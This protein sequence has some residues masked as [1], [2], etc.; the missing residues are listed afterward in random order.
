MFEL[1]V[2]CCCDQDLQSITG[3]QYNHIMGNYRVVELH[4]SDECL[5]RWFCLACQEEVE[6][7]GTMAPTCPAR[8][9]HESS[10]PH[11]AAVA[12]KAAR[13]QSRPQNLLQQRVDAGQAAAPD[14]AAQQRAAKRAKQMHEEALGQGP[15]VSSVAAPPLCAVADMLGAYMLAGQLNGDLSKQVQVAGEELSRVACVPHSGQH[16]ACTHVALYNMSESARVQASKSA[17]PSTLQQ[18][19]Q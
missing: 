6:Q 5:S 17:R 4:P 15:K 19:P 13:L 7:R 1:A 3:I 12:R 18:L 11:L 2:N 9:A 14:S 8:L 10:P 16:L